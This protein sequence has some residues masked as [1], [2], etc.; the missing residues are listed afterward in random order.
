MKNGSL[1]RL[2]ANVLG[3]VGLL[4]VLA[5]ALPAAAV[6][7]SVVSFNVNSG[8]HTDP[9]K[10]AQDIARIEPSDLWGLQEVDGPQALAVL[11]A[12]IGS[13]YRTILGKSGD[14]KGVPDDNLA[15]VFNPDV[16]ELV[17]T[18][19]LQHVEGSR[20][21]LV[22]RFV[23]RSSGQ[24]FLFA[25]NH[26][27]RNRIRIRERQVRQFSAW[28]RSQVLPVV[29]VGVYNFDWRLGRRKG[30]STFNLMQQDAIFKWVVPGCLERGDCP[31]TGSQCDPALDRIQSFIFVTG[32][33]KHWNVKSDLLFIDDP[34]YCRRYGQGHSGHRPIR[35]MVRIEAAG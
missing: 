6:E 28:A 25:V 29:A 7:F 20:K 24:K 8:D 17:G 16:L 3:W 10:V 15:I 31:A 1:P 27:Q 5:A 23:L 32:P 35:A 12:A 14:Y 21:P 13:Q 33:A 11:A 2:R 4:A 9:D 22:A 19:E 34:D 30:N 18:K 26:L